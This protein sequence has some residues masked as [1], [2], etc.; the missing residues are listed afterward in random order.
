MIYRSAHVTYHSVSAQCVSKNVENN[1][2]VCEN[3]CS[4]CMTYHSIH[5]SYRSIHTTYYSAHYA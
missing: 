4:I 2:Y 1:Q 3:Y 5:I